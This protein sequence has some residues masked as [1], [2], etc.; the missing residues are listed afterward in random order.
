MPNSVITPLISLNEHPIR[1]AAIWPIISSGYSP[2]SA[3]P[4]GS[5]VI[6]DNKLY[7]CIVAID[8]PGE[9][10]N[11]THWVQ[12]TLNEE[13]Q[14]LPSGSI[15]ELG[16]AVKSVNNVLPDENGNVQLLRVASADNLASDETIVVND[17]F[18]ERIAGGEASV[19]SGPSSLGVLYGYS[20]RTGYS[21]E[22]KNVQVIPVTRQDDSELITVGINWN[23]YKTAVSGVST[24]KIFSYTDSWSEDPETYGII[25][26]GTPV[27][28]DEISVS[29]TAENRGTIV[30][31][32]P[33]SFV[34]TNWNLYDSTTGRCRVLKYSDDYGF[35]IGGTYT[36]IS[37]SSTIDGEQTTITPDSN[38]LFTISEDGYLFVENGNDTDTYVLMT[39]SDWNNGYTG[40]FQVH[41]ESVIDF[42]E[43][44]S[45]TFPFGLCAIGIVMDEINFNN[46]IAYVR[47]GRSAYSAENLAVAEASGRDFVYDENWIYFVKEI[48]DQVRFNISNSITV[49]DHGMEY[50]TGTVLPVTAYQLYG[51]NL[52][53]KLRNE[54]VAVTPQNFSVAQK[55]I[56]RQNIEAAFDQEVIKTIN[57]KTPDQYGDITIVEGTANASYGLYIVNISIQPAAWSLI[58]GAYQVIYTDPLIKS[59]MTG[60][61]TWLDDPSVMLGK[62]RFSTIDGSLIISTAVQPTETWGLHVNLGTNGATVL[63]QVRNKTEESAIAIVEYD[64]TAFHNIASGQYVLWKS[65]LYKAD[66]AITAGDTLTS[67]GNDANLS[68][69]ND[70]IGNNLISLVGAE[71]TSRENAINSLNSNITELLKVKSFNSGTK[72]VNAGQSAYID[73]NISLSGYKPIAVATLTGSGTSSFAFQDWYFTSTSNFRIYVRNLG[74][75]SITINSITVGVLFIKNNSNI[76]G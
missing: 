40:D 48:P 6:V 3:Y 56:A 45:N 42:S 13:L 58:N 75:S 30:N 63:E 44:M 69:V 9:P 29:F 2:L 5:Y 43:L 7:R 60:I 32:T 71:R 1:D 66:S 25:V 12:T 59:D 64:D 74:S 46:K 23:T 55:A 61:E 54:V 19:P 35:K 17:T 38:G 70:G 72:T 10:W 22:S 20:I 26:S 36:S 62:T 37:F 27:N 53:N 4:V 21:S 14:R 52:K 51:L 16:K 57:H 73:I 15:E 34:E 18:V 39:K 41:S 50:F 24:N 31:T 47:I 65:V 33:T 28:G 76:N 68:I 67:S 49:D 11:S 8:D